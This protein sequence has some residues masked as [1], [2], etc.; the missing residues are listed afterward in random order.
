M[1]LESKPT[2]MD[3]ERVP[4]DRATAH[5]LAAEW[6]GLREIDF[7]AAGAG[8]TGQ[9]T[10]ALLQAFHAVLHGRHPRSAEWLDNVGTNSPASRLARAHAAA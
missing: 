2:W 10:R 3:S 9:V 5:L 4:F 1:G 7:R 8:K 6:I